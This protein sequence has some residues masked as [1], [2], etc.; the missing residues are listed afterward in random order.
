M[1]WT[2]DRIEEDQAVIEVTADVM[3]TLPLSA[4]PPETREGDV[5]AVSVD[6][7]LTMLRRDNARR[8][9]S[10]LVHRPPMEKQ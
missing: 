4:L 2:V 10:R 5:L 9:L 7:A 6:P 8:R 3:L 1:H